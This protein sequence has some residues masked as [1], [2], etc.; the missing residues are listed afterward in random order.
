MLEKTP[1]S[2]FDVLQA[3]AERPEPI[4]VFLAARE[5]QRVEDLLV[6]DRNR[7]FE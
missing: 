6:M 5:T 4:P 1:V 3:A 7:L 2:V